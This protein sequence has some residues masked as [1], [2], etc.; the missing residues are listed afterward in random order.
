[1]KS[2]LNALWQRVQALL[3]DEA[4]ASAKEAWI[5]LQQ[6]S[7][8]FQ[9]HSGWL[10]LGLLFSAFAIALFI[11]PNDQAWLSLIRAS[12]QTSNG[13]LLSSLASSLSLTGDFHRLNAGLIVGFIALARMTY[14]PR[15]RR[16][17]MVCLLSSALSGITAVSARFMLGRARPVARMNGN[18]YGPDFRTDYQGCPSGH[19]ATAF[20]AAVPLVIA[21]PLVG[22]PVVALASGV[23]WSRL[24]VNKHYPTDIAAGLWVAMIFGLPFGWVARR[25]SRKS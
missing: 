20:G 25:G 9:R 23:A 15:W 24:Y 3:K 8:W 5:L 17:A 10:L 2:S 19:T 16:L 21:D 13:K 6:A 1:M 14:Q 18:F 4:M 11:Y 22:I 12:R 7:D